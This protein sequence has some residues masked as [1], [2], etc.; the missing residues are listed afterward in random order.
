MQEFI[1]SFCEDIRKMLEAAGSQ[2]EVFLEGKRMLSQFV[3]EPLFLK[4]LYSQLVKDDEFLSS[5]WPAMDA[6]EITVYREK[7]GE[8]SLRLY[9]WD[10][11]I[12]YPIHSHG[13]WG[14][15][16]CVAGVV[17]ERKFERLDD[18]TKPGY[19][20]IRETGRELLKPG[21]TTTV[22][23]LNEGLHQMESYAKEHSS[24]SL[25]L[26]GRAVRGGFIE[27][28][29]RH[30]ETAYKVIPPKL[31]S[32]LYAVKSMAA[33]GMDWC[34]E[35]L[36]AAAKDKKAFMRYEA[37]SALSVLDKDAA[38]KSI[39]EELTKDSDLKEEFLALLKSITVEN[40]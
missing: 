17:Q 30:K 24:V 31:Y 20:K 32:R 21:G 12:T 14:V 25:H 40:T 33:I 35:L 36:E 8:F 6:N 4:E 23:P 34:M 15:V 11:L 27:F 26:Y 28:Y 3:R 1:D 7:N 9:V 22:L 10:P 38:V 39:K 5:R 37:I 13:S 16:A 29:D 19:A 2:E 18:A